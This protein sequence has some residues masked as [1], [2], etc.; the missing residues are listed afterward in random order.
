MDLDARQSPVDR[1]CLGVEQ[2]QC[3]G[4]DQH[5]LAGDLLARHAALQEIDG[6]D[7]A[8]LIVMGEVDPDSPGR[9]G[10]Q[11]EAGERH[12]AD[13]AGRRADEDGAGAGDDPQHLQRQGRHHRAFGQHHHGHAPH[14]AVRL[15]Q[16]AEQAAACRGILQHR[17]V[18]AQ[19]GKLDHEGLGV[20][21]QHAKS[22]LRHRLGHRFALAAVAGLAEHDAHPAD[23][24]GEHLVIAGKG[25][26]AL[27]R[28]L[29][30]IAEPGGDARGRQPIGLGEDHVEAHRNGPEAGQP[31]QQVGD[32]G[33]R[34]GPLPEPLEATLI[35]VEDDNRPDGGIT[36]LESL[37]EVEGAQPDCLDGRRIPNAQRRQPCQQ[38]KR[39]QPAETD[40]LGKASQEPHRSS[41]LR[42]CVL[43]LRRAETRPS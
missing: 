14:D 22:G 2:P 10:R 7:V 25:G 15:R 4:A 36:R 42:G 21:P 35:D 31:P 20:R 23:H 11:L 30:E 40:P 37:V 34:P 12:G 41:R 8:G 17:N 19:H 3:R 33:P 29:V 38:D 24:P 16:D 6:R 13:A 27:A 32:L 26:Q 5:E 9:I 1:G 18:P 39:K 28:L 43:Q